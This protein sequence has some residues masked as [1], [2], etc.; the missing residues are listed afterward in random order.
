MLP[1]ESTATPCGLLKAPA[2]PV[3]AGVTATP[4]LQT[5]LAGRQISKAPPLVTVATVAELEGLPPL[6]PAAEEVSWA[7]LSPPR[8]PPKVISYG[9]VPVSLPGPPVA[10]T[11]PPA[12]P[13]ELSALTAALTWEPLALKA[14]G[15]V[16]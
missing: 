4:A 7:T 8:T 14:I 2:P 10:L 5:S 13:T 15:A 6:R 16:V 9:A 3:P 11:E 12:P 1:A